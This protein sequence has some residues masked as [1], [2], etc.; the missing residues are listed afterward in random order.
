M[1]RGS[2]SL[3]GPPGV[4]GGPFEGTMPKYGPFKEFLEPWERLLFRLYALRNRDF[5][6]NREKKRGLVLRRVFSMIQNPGKTVPR[7]GYVLSCI[8]AMSQ[9]HWIDVRTRIYQI[10]GNVD[11][12]R[13]LADH[14]SDHCKPARRGS[15]GGEAVALRKHLRDL[16][17]SDHPS[18]RIAAGTVSLPAP[19][20]IRR[21]FAVPVDADEACPQED[22]FGPPNYGTEQ[23]P[24]VIPNVNYVTRKLCVG[25]DAGN[26]ESFCLKSRFPGMPEDVKN[27]VGIVRRPRWAS[28][29][30]PFEV[31]HLNRF[32][33][34]E[35]FGGANSVAMEKSPKT[36]GRVYEEGMYDNPAQAPVPLSGLINLEDENATFGPC[37]VC[38]LPSRSRECMRCGH[39]H[40]RCYTPSKDVCPD[41]P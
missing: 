20:S 38:G 8:G 16:S 30:T 13:L 22:P 2:S 6:A 25:S 26:M 4:P 36:L 31:G 24:R 1:N 5:C 15:T 19:S 11:L 23:L 27:V 21:R 9:D 12:H 41:S 14:I 33:Y 40:G 32:L 35:K 3:V 34:A 7:Y 18:C 28:H 17:L 39:E 10:V 37:E 29:T